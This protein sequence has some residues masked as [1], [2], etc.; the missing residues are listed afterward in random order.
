MPTFSSTVVIANPYPTFQWQT[1]NVNV[2]GA[3]STNLTLTNVQYAALNGATVSM[4]ASNAAGMVT[5]SAT[6]TVIVRAGHQPATDQH[7]GQCG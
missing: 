5:N 3:T 7:Y 6:L 4:I 2:D 1:N